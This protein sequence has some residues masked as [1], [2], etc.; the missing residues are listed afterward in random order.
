M[1]KCQPAKV[2]KTEIFSFIFFL[3]I[4]TQRTYFHSFLSPISFL[5]KNGCCLGI[6]KEWH[7]QQLENM[8]HKLYNRRFPRKKG[9]AADKQHKTRQNNFHHHF[10][11]CCCC[12]LWL[13]GRRGTLLCCCVLWHSS[14][15][16]TIEVLS[17][18]PFNFL[19]PSFIV[20]PRTLSSFLSALPT[21]KQQELCSL[22]AHM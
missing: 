21:Y 16:I 2:G 15:K 9:G 18:L 7:K 5:R 1:C 22:R 14:D 3:F 12:C 19:L 11:S 6:A 8:K 4:L 17:P 13:V 10:I 20:D